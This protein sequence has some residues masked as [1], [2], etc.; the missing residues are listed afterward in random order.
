MVTGAFPRVGGLPY[1]LHGLLSEAAHT[2]P[3]REAVR[4]AGQSITYGELDAAANGLA[5]ALIGEDVRRGDR[6]A[7]L[8]PKSIEM[9][10][11]V[12]GVRE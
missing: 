1:V 7:I 10:A 12:Y 9:V 6:V 11:S 2:E 3:G 5:R 4:C 8:L